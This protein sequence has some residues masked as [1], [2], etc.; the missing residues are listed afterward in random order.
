MRISS[1][2][3]TSK[4]CR[5]TELLEDVSLIFSN[6]IFLSSI[7]KEFDVFVVFGPDL[8]DAT[9]GAVAQ[10]ENL[11]PPFVEFALLEWKIE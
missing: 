5:P 11:F 4:N 1:P 8:N 6:L 9:V 3:G 10:M 7:T 2:L